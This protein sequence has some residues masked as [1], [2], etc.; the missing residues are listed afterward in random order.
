MVRKR[1][2][3]T[4]A[5][6]RRMINFDLKLAKLRAYYSADNPKG[7]YGVISQYMEEHGFNHTQYSGY[8][9]KYAMSR[10]GVLE[11]IDEICTTFPWLGLCI[12]KLHSTIIDEKQFSLADYAYKRSIAA[13]KIQNID[14]VKTPD[15]HHFHFDNTLNDRMNEAND[16][17][18]STEK[19]VSRVKVRK[20]DH[21]SLNDL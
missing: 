11:F 20:K 6:R 1:R 7:A 16:I 13:R 10:K 15:P 2:N 18:K 19:S 3:H 5:K 9:S 21:P 14:F 8:E 12:N 4:Q 17:S